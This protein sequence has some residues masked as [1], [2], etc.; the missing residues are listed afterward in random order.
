[1]ILAFNFVGE[2]ERQF[3]RRTL[4]AGNFLLGEKV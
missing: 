1:M 4:C 2:I 3:F